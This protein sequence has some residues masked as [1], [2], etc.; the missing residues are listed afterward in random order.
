M[1]LNGTIVKRALLFHCNTV[2]MLL[3]GSI[4][5]RAL[6]FRYNTRNNATIVVHYIITMPSYLILQVILL[7]RDVTSV[8]IGSGNLLY[9]AIVFVGI[10]TI[11][12][13]I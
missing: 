11:R 1:P 12:R 2:S 10:G 8:T 3:N 13:V 7:R 6:L 9:F 5:K 4:I